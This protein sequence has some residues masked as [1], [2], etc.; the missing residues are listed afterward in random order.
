MKKLFVLFASAVLC[1]RCFAAV[2]ENPA[3]LAVTQGFVFV[4]LPLGFQSANPGKILSLVPTVSKPGAEVTYLLQPRALPTGVASL[5][6]W[7]PAG[8][9]M[10]EEWKGR[11]VQGYPPITVRAGHLTDLG[12]LVP[13]P[14]GNKEVVVL[15]FRNHEVAPG[16]AA[17]LAAYAG[18]LSPDKV[19][20]WQVPDVPT[21]PAQQANGL[22]KGEVM[23]ALAIVYKSEKDDS[24]MIRKMAA[25][26][27]RA[28]LLQLAQASMPPR[29][30]A[31]AVDAQARLY[32][33]ADLGII[34]VRT[35]AGQWSAIDT[36]SLHSVTAVAVRGTTLVAGY[37]N[38]KIRV[39]NIDGSGWRDAATLEWNEQVADIDFVGGRWLVATRRRDPAR[40]NGTPGHM[41]RIQ[42]YAAGSDDFGDLAVIRTL[43]ITPDD[44]RQYET[45]RAEVYRDSYYLLATPYFL[46]LNTGDMSWDELN[47]SRQ[48]R[49]MHV[50]PSTEMLTLSGFDGPITSLVQVSTDRGASWRKLTPPRVVVLDA[51]FEN[52]E[53]GRASRIDRFVSEKTFKTLI[54]LPGKNDWLTM[55]KSPEECVALLPDDK[56]VHRFCTTV[57]GSIYT[58]LEGGWQIELANE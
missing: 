3:K 20:E 7:L 19:I 11:W 54:Y 50:S 41:N 35:P 46:R 45:V 34:R 12:Q 48:V 27:T 28:Q 16:R 31:P 40:P 42:V 4:Q 43:P 9:Y 58:H 44:Y 49:D 47:A 23:D 51:Y 17:M 32:Y 14:I 37:P 33:G 21:T 6:L 38:G 25:A 8:Q 57:A 24:P 36:G 39:G 30:D 52:P 5:G 22:R 56:H 1:L 53:E 2:P 10:I 29:T 26:E 55:T 18:V 15:P 13:I